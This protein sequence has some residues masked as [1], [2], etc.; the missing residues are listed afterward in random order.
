[1]QMYQAARRGLPADALY[2]QLDRMQQSQQRVS[3]GS[4]KL[5]NESSSATA[6]RQE[7]AFGTAGATPEAP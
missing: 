6:T 7:T 4:C 1:M 5:Q 2:K 3:S